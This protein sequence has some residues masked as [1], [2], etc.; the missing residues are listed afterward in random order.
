M[1]LKDASSLTPQIQ[2]S[3]IIDSLAPTD[4]ETNRL[5][6][7]SPKYMG[8]LATLLSDTPKEVLQIYFIWKATQ[9]FTSVLEA[10]ELK[11]YTQFE[12]DLRGRVRLVNFE[13]FMRC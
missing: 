6:V 2:L 3:K 10:D 4:V 5:I 7:S 9:A 13:P 12:N 1:S 8:T 11:P